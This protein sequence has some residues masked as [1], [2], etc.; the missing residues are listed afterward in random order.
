[1][2]AAVAGLVRLCDTLPVRQGGAMAL[3]CLCLVQLVDLSPA[4][5]RKFV[6]LREYSPIVTDLVTGTTPALST[7]T[8]FFETIRGRYHTI[9]AL[10]PLNQTGLE[11]ALY[12]ADEGMNSTDTAVVARY[13]EEA[14]AARRTGFIDEVLAGEMRPDCLYVTER[15]ETFLQLADTADQQGAWCGA[16]YASEGEGEPG[17]VLYVIAPGLEDYRHT[18]AV[19]YGENFPL[20]VADYSDDY[21]YEGILSTNLADIGRE[22][23]QNKVALFYDTPLAR[24]RLTAGASIL[25]DGQRYPILQVDDSDKGWLMVTLDTA[26]ARPLAGKDL[27]IE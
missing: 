7:T 18:L 23:D 22:S 6:S 20:R 14:A 11:L 3:A 1:M 10:D 26:D 8:D 5:A 12:A 4:L 19:P 17:P 16:L 21:W 27:V 25:C 24:R 2:L 13:D 9:I 15:P